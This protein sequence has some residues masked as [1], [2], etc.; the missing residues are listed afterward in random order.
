MATP[1]AQNMTAEELEAAV[2]Q[3]TPMILSTFA[4]QGLIK[5]TETGYE[6]K[7]EL[8]DGKAS[9]NGTAITF[10]FAPQ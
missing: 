6:T 1:Q 10:P 2:E 5:E 8:K 4:Q 3:Q 9:V 7:L